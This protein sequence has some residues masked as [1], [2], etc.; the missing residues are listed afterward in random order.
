MERLFIRWIKYPNDAPIRSFWENWLKKFPDMQETVE[1]AAELVRRASDWPGDS[2]LS[3][4][5]V[6]SLW[7][8]IRTSIGQVKEM[9]P[10]QSRIDILKIRLLYYRWYVIGGT[11]AL[12]VLAFLVFNS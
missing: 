10:L 2:G 4:E 12:I 9:E 5:D 8:R 7:G 6:N 1:L 11:L 3:S